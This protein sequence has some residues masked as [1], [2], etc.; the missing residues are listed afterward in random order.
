MFVSEILYAIEKVGERNERGMEHFSR[1]SIISLLLCVCVI[2]AHGRKSKRPL[3]DKKNA[4]KTT[5]TLPDKFLSI[6]HYC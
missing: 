4:L 1:Q 2:A 5:E 6:Q 3:A